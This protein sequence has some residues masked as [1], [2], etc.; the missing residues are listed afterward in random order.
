MKTKQQFYELCKINL[1]DFDICE[2]KSTSRPFDGERSKGTINEVV[3]HR[4]RVC[5]K[6][7]VCSVTLKIRTAIVNETEVTS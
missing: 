4:T 3:D 7:V 2:L 1:I 5:E 6:K